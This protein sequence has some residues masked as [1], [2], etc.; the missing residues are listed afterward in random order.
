[1]YYFKENDLL[2]RKLNLSAK[3]ETLLT[4]EISNIASRIGASQVVLDNNVRDDKLIIGFYDE[5]PL[6]FMAIDITLSGNAEEVP[7][8]NE[9]I[10][11]ETEEF[12]VVLLSD[13]EDR[14]KDFVDKNGTTEEVI[15]VE[16]SF[17]IIS[18]EDYWYGNGY[19][20]FRHA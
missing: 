11:A 18:K 12:F 3:E 13:V 20:I 15:R 9:P 2:I 4:E 14:V 8:L 7:L 17:A 6:A 10:V 1:M 19:N 16:P 5:K